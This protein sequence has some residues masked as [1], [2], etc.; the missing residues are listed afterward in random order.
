MVQFE[1]VLIKDVEE[2]PSFL[3]V[4]TFQSLIEEDI[5]DK[6]VFY[7]QKHYNGLEH[8]YLISK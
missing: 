6:R 2:Q 8:F 3:S 5:M 7:S 4:I 1:L